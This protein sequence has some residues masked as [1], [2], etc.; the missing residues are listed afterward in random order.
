MSLNHP[1]AASVL[2][3]KSPSPVPNRAFA[4]CELAN[5]DDEA[6]INSAMG[7]GPFH[8]VRLGGIFRIERLLQDHHYRIEFSLRDETTAIQD[9][10]QWSETHENVFRE[11]FEPPRE[12]LATDD[13]LGI[14]KA[15][16]ELRVIYQFIINLSDGDHRRFLRFRGHKGI[17]WF[18]DIVSDSYEECEA[19]WQLLMEKYFIMHELPSS[20]KYLPTVKFLTKGGRND[21][22]LTP[23]KMVDDR[24][25]DAEELV[26]HYGGK[27]ILT[28]EQEVL[29]SLQ[30]DNAGLHLLQGA[31]GVGKTSL[32]LHLISK[33]KTCHQ[34][35]YLPTQYFESISSPESF[36]FWADLA[37]ERPEGKR[38]VLI[39]EDA[40]AL[41]QAREQVSG[42]QASLVS[43][44]LN[45][46]VGILGQALGLQVV[47]TF[48][49]HVE[50]N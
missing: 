23:M 50:K 30:N 6:L 16:E 25:M 49:T 2:P 10:D 3:S 33:I 21:F 36:A 7:P 18:A 20:R 15:G 19:I 40:E 8:R 39:V 44:L 43:N 35:V 12:S 45:C 5:K 14:R 22:N 11:C 41:I 17:N 37:K 47:A 1:S 26:L 46:T 9:R 34:L 38:T 24:Q 32:L 4:E 13:Y 48:N 31:P 28:Y 27:E 42:Y 29:D